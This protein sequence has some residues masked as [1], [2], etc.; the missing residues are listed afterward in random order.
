MPIASGNS[1]L[2]AVFWYDGEN[3]IGAEEPLDGMHVI[4][5]G[6]YLQLDLMHFDIWRDYNQIDIGMEYDEL[7]RGR[8]LFKIPIHQFIVYASRAIVEKCALNFCIIMDFRKRLFLN[9]IYIMVKYKQGMILLPPNYKEHGRLKP[10]RVIAVD[11]ERG[12]LWVATAS[13]TRTAT[14]FPIDAFDRW[15]V[16]GDDQLNLNGSLP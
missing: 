11:E 3:F 1:R 2:L 9:T 8:I 10:R 13:E 4:Q 14:A 5:Y 15:T 6:D 12:L 16:D 7:P